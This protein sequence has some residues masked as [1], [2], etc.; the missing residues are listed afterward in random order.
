[1]NDWLPSAILYQVNLRAWAAREPRNPAE[2]AGEAS[3]P[4]GSPLAHLT[5]HLESV[6]GLGATVVYVMPP[7]PIGEIE[8]KGI[9]SPYAIRDFAAV[10]PEFG[11]LDEMRALVRRAHDLGLK[12]ILDITPNHT[13]RDH[14]WV[15]AHPEY[16]VR[17]AGGGL[18]HDYDWTD[19]YKLDYRAP[20]LR[21]AMTD[22]YR[23][24]LGLL[25]PG[26]HGRP[27]GVDGF[28]LD[29][30]H[31]ISDTSFWSEALPV[32]RAE[33]SN[34]RL[35][36]LAESY[37]A[38]NNLGLFARGMDAAYDDD[39]YKVCAFGYALDANGESAVRLDPGAERVGD[40]A[41]SLAAFRADGI[42]GAFRH[43]LQVYERRFPDGASGPR[44]AR[45]TDNHD[46]GRG[47][48]R[49]G[50]G[51][52]RAVQRLIY[53]SGHCL[54]FL[55]AGQEYGAVNRPPIH[56]RLGVC[57]KGRWRLRPGAAPDF[58][59]G[60]EF[61]GNLFARTPA[62]RRAWREFFGGLI[63][64]RSA[65]PLLQTGD[66]HALDAGEDA[67]RPERAVLAFER[68]HGAGA[69]RI[70]VNL[71]AE[72]RRLKKADAFRGPTLAGGLDGGDV[73]PPFGWIVI[74]PDGEP[75]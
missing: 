46:E 60:V 73:L 59:P 36:F 54:P 72:P 68:R 14:V 51:A 56:A 74:K 71:G 67:P 5:E 2:A 37:G 3:G 16:Y 24:W 50:S 15:R 4:A 30:A 70:A 10:D 55:L 21:R 22:V 66:V 11:T 29:M 43:T 48:Y 65:E 39:F 75:S 45:Y 57:D 17:A 49:F 28:R 18:Y 7:Y 31:H 63:R 44:L 47:L 32:L 41:E 8:R 40:F 27:D 34:R 61:E 13:A 35:L 53:L 26:A 25:G 38:A 69:L 52:V 19:T 1:M 12:V 42:A 9:G 23:F 58:E 62:E 20:A 6:A 33:H 64:L